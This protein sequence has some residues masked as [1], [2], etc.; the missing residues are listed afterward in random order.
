MVLSQRNTF[1]CN[2]I[3]LKI[4]WG[5]KVILRH[6]GDLSC[7]YSF[8]SRINP[9]WLWSLPAFLIFQSVPRK[10]SVKQRPCWTGL[11]VCRQKCCPGVLPWRRCRAGGGEGDRDAAN[12][13]CTSQ[14]RAMSPNPPPIFLSAQQPVTLWGDFCCWFSQLNFL[15]FCLWLQALQVSLSCLDSG[16]CFHLT[17]YFPLRLGWFLAVF[18]GCFVPFT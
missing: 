9:G 3:Y 17:F 8:S 1:L 4:S 10:C 11:R 16:P 7:F 5:Q 15:F 14:S 13:P 12:K 2:F 6:R 18:E